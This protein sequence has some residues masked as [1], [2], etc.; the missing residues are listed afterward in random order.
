MIRP[1]ELKWHLEI[2][3]GGKELPNIFLA[4]ARIF[5][6]LL[7]EGIDVPYQGNIMGVISTCKKPFSVNWIFIF[8][9]DILVLFFWFMTWSHHTS[10]L[11]IEVPYAK[12]LFPSM[13]GGHELVE[14]MWGSF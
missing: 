12:L 8:K 1:P 2:I 11:L 13:K 3:E 6:Y 7:L 4:R 10:F 5:H 14:M 9:V